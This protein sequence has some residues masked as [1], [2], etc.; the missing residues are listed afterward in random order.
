MRGMSGGFHGSSPILLV[1]NFNLD[2]GRSLWVSIYDMNNLLGRRLN[3]EGL[4]PADTKYVNGE[5]K[6]QNIHRASDRILD[7]CEYAV[8]HQGDEG[9]AAALRHPTRSRRNRGRRWD[10]H[11]R[12][13]TTLVKT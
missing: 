7:V 12:A 13:R 1:K 4:Y 6:I 11:P 5:E 9:A 2:R 8:R 10:T 3:R